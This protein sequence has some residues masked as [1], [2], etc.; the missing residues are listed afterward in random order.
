MSLIYFTVCFWNQEEIRVCRFDNGCLHLSEPRQHKGQVRG[1]RWR[2]ET[3]ATEGKWKS[4]SWKHPITDMERRWL[5]FFLLLLWNVVEHLCLFVCG[6]F[7]RCEIRVWQVMCFL[8]GGVSHGPRGP[9]SYYYMLPMKVR[10]QG[11][12]V[13]LSSKMA[14]VSDTCSIKLRI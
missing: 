2:Q 1:Q 7:L 9:T 5:I 4:S 8:S 14:Q 6:E 3:M 11:L 13:A 10:V 12:K